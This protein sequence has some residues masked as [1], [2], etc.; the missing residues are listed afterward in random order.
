LYASER[1]RGL[2][3]D[4]DFVLT[5][6]TGRPLSQHNVCR[7]V[8]RAG[9]AAGLGHVTPKMLRTTVATAYAKAGVDRDEA[10]AITGHS[11]AVYDKHYVKPHRDRI[12]RENAVKRLLKSGYG[13]E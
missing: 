10:A 13:T 9:K 11:T 7:M 12:E 5:T 3:G 6:R 2:G 1:A 8:R 4:D